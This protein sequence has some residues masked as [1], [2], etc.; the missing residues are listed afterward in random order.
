VIHTLLALA[1]AAAPAVK[2]AAA[3][4]AP[5][6]PPAVAKP[7]PPADRTVIDRVA[8][9]L[10][11][12]VVTLRDLQERAGD[13]WTRAAASPAGPQRDEATRRVL[14]R[15]WE[16]VQAERLFRA[17]ATTL[18]LEVSDAQVDGAVEDIK[19]RNQFSDQQL[20]Q[21]L[22]GQGLDRAGFKAQIRRELESMQVLNY[23]VRS[24][25]KVTEEDLQNYYKTHPSAFGGQEELHVRLLFLPLAADADPATVRAAEARADRLVQRLAAG[26]DFTALVK[27]VSGGQDGDLGWLSRGHI[28]QQL[29]AAFVGLADGQVSKVV[30]AST[31]LHLFKVEGRRATGGRTFEAA[32]DEIRDT[33]VQEQTASYREQFLAELRKDAVIELR[34]PELKD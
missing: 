33:L 1:L 25:V 21:A 16:A 5:V 34:L 29:E 14:R 13:E 6:D 19:T 30:R 18:G 3:P 20:D 32:K 27:E 9:V 11:G 28:Q 10:N 17:Q 8:A 24:R 15:A 12:E 31:G 2:P 26:E 4:T 23:K 22:V 7:R